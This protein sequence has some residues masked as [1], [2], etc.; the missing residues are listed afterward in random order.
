MDHKHTTGKGPTSWYAHGHK[1]IGV[2]S[3]IQLEFV[4]HNLIFEVHYIKKTPL[5]KILKYILNICS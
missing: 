5:N 1:W 3:H 2:I 4:N